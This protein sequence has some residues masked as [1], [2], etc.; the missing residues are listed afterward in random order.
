MQSIPTLPGIDSQRLRSSRLE[1]R[2]LT[3]GP[4][5]GTP[6]VFVHGNLSAA[7]WWEEIMLALPP[8]FR[9]VAFDQRGYG[10]ADPQAK[11][12]ATRGV[13]DLSEDLSALLDVLGL[14]QVHLVGHSLG[15]SVLWR[16]LMDHSQ[17]IRSVTQVCPGSPFGFG[18]CLPEGTACFPD[19]AG[20]GGGTVGRPFIERLQAGD[21]SDEDPQSSP[22][23][24]LNSLV[25]KPPFVPA[26]MEDILTATLATH[27]G[28][29]DYPGDFQPSPHWP[30]VAP[31][32]YGAVNALSPLYQEPPDRLYEL[33]V[34]PPILWI[35]G[36]SDLVVS[37][38][39]MADFGTLGKLGF[40]PEWPGEKVFPSQPMVSQ[41]EEV[42]HE[43]ARRGGVCNE[44][45]FTDCGHSPYLEDPEQF[46]RV[47]HAFITA[48]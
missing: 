36:E 24:V 18:G 6:V 28:E 38:Q 25:W 32:R 44:V 45:V 15:G 9:G 47:F 29:Q 46:N 26:R 20:S 23:N 27:L 42:L 40:I 10:E 19:G 33:E 48:H 37:D 1:T 31:G 14:K 35:R 4:T 3:C 39:S 12:D 5:D 30:G 34:K 11:I 7:T 22:R 13:R 21:R 16:F 43:Y 41:T 8:E 2:V 17:R